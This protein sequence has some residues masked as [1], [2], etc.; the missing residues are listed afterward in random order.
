MRLN[1][2]KMDDGADMQL[3]IFTNLSGDSSLFVYI[4]QVTHVFSGD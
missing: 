2:G 4:R 3:P 1:V